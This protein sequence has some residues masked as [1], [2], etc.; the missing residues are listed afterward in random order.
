MKNPCIIIRI[1]PSF[2]P[3][4]SI[5]PPPFPPEPEHQRARANLVHFEKLR[6]GQ[7]DSEDYDDDFNPRIPLK[8]YKTHEEFQNYEKLCR[9]E[10]TQVC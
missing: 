5:I 3:T 6:A 1:I 4:H 2:T 8:D 10:K 7:V 9:G